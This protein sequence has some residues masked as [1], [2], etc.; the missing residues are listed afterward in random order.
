MKAVAAED[1]IK[2]PSLGKTKL[3][4]P[5]KER[6]DIFFQKRIF[7]GEAREVVYREA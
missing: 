5:V 2:T 3:L 1:L 6:M 7:S 4:D